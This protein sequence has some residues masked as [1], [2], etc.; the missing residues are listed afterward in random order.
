[1]QSTQ[2]PKTS[3]AKE[4]RAAEPLQKP[5]ATIRREC[6]VCHSTPE[7]GFVSIGRPV[8][9]PRRGGGLLQCVSRS[10]WSY[11]QVCARWSPNCSTVPYWYLAVLHSDQGL[12]DKIVVL[13]YQFARAFHP[14][15]ASHDLS[16]SV[17]AA[18]FVRFAKNGTCFHF[19]WL[20]SRLPASL[21]RVLHLQ[22]RLHIVPAPDRWQG[23]SDRPF[24]DRG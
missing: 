14:L 23:Q 10:R 12:L 17:S 3:R 4:S 11:L 24:L 7:T 13:Q 19:Q 9:P 5:I 8:R 1:M 2:P 21:P 18:G 15:R 16:Y 22:P 20:K 6:D